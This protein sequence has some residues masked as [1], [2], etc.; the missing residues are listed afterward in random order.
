MNNS[1]TLASRF[2]SICFLCV[3]IFLG[4][5]S[6]SLPLE[7]RVAEDFNDQ[8]CFSLAFEYL[9]II[10]SPLSSVLETII[11]LVPLVL[12]I[13]VAVSILARSS[14]SERSRS[15][16]W[17]LAAVILPRL[18]TYANQNFLSALNFHSS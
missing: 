14:K 10:S 3:G 17:L 18:I 16:C 8:N 7:F 12:A 9:S 11:V 13:S 6:I 5:M 4:R 2:Q 15:F 1:N